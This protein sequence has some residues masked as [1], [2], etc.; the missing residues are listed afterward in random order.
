M[1]ESRVSAEERFTQQRLPGQEKATVKSVY[2]DIAGEYDGRIPGSGQ[3]DE[4]FTETEMDFLLGKITP[5]ERVLD[6]GCGTGRFTAPLAATG[7]EVTG[8]D[9]S[10]GMLT[11][12]RKKLAERGLKAEMRQGDMA[13]LPFP[14]ATFDTVTSMLALMHIPLA[15]RQA[16]FIEASR[17]LKPGGRMLLCVKNSV[18]ERLFKGDRFASVDVTDVQDKKLIFTETTSGAA[19]TAPWYSF[20]PHELAALFARAGMTVTHLR[21]N[22]PVSV[23]LAEE[24]LADLRAVVQGLERA[25]SDVP[26]FS[27]LGYHLLAEAVKPLI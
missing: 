10:S 9:L 11:V 24:V 4:I 3:S 1:T 13:E 18:F 23:W 5:G 14:D 2:D 19:Q 25:L 21:G 6:M 20:A 17:V 16:V 26:P 27:H 8:L 7:A 12:A 22:S 15:D